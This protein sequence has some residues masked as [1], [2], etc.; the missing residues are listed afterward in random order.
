[1]RKYRYTP[2]VIL[3]ILLFISIS[4]ITADEGDP[5]VYGIVPDIPPISFVNDE[6]EPDGFLVELF[7]EIFE[8]LELEY[9]IKPAPYEEIYTGM[10]NG[11]IDLFPSMIKTAEREQLFYFPEQSIS[12]GWGQFFTYSDAEFDS[13]LSLRNK[14]IGMVRGDEIG[15]NFIIFMEELNIP[16]TAVEFKTFGLLLA[17]IRSG[18]VYGGVI[19]NAYLLGIQDIKI[20]PT[21]FS[22]Q[23]SY[24]VTALN[25]DFIPRLDKIVKHLKELKSDDNSYYYALQSK[26]LLYNESENRKYYSI[27][28]IFLLALIGISAFLSF[29]GFYLQKVIKKRTGEVKQAATIFDHSIEGIMVTDKNLNIIQV[30]N[31]FTEI[32]GYKSREVLGKPVSFLKQPEEYPEVIKEVMEHLEKNGKWV[33]ETW[34]RRKNGE[35]YPQ[36]KSIVIINDKNGQPLNYSFVFTDLSQN[37]ELEERIHYMSNYD[38]Q[39]DLP[40]KTL[41]RDRLIM[42]GINADREGNIIC[43]ISLGLDNF[44]K[45]NRSFGHIT[46]DLVLKEVGERLRTVC[47]KSDTV[48]RY[49]GDEFTLLL[50][51]MNSQEDVLRI[52]E[53]IKEELEKP[54]VIEGKTIY[55]SCSQGISLYPSDNSDITAISRNANQAQHIAKKAGKGTYAFY[56]EDDDI[57]LKKRHKDEMMLRTAVEKDEILVYYQPKYDIKKEKVTGVEALVRWNKENS[58]LVYPDEFISI[59]EESRLIIPIGEYILEQSCS[60]I[61]R[62][63]QTLKEPIKLAVNLSGVQ[64]SD[65]KLILKIKEILNNTNFPPELLEIEITESIAMHDLDNTLQILEELTSLGIS[66]AVDDFGTG[67]SSLSYLQRFP[68]ST[69]KIDKSFI[70]KLDVKEED[71]GIVKTII[72]L[73]KIMNL[74]VVAEGVET[75]TQIEIL[76]N[77]NCHEAQGYFISKPT[78]LKKLKDFLSKER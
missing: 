57:A 47:R 40:N 18:K 17:E 45:I 22:P 5:I 55:S 24:P 29:N 49:G 64:F 1:M 75:E 74:N 25:S 35:I 11:E 68:L 6:G 63:N 4:S 26:W 7:T 59:L 53:K 19:Y 27:I 48:S 38:R 13:I 56:R 76:R 36:H 62:L 15:R 50:T 65:L 77:N 66:I 52:I 71:Q 78:S 60:D 21:V 37:H 34:D 28:I 41:F 20:T 54:L 2:Q 39:T 51:D 72:S 23:P 73:A 67:Y 46:G 16:F 14:K 30:N 58:E 9:I 32:T 10:L 70:D 8:D 3:A 12:G 43:V 31:A 33:G 69:L 42:A 61:A 44:K